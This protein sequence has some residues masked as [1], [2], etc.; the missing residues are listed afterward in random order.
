MAT[1]KPKR[2]RKAEYER[3]KARK[4]AEA[5]RVS[6]VEV[7]EHDPEEFR[8]RRDLINAELALLTQRT[9]DL[10]TDADRDIDF[11]YRHAGNPNLTPLQAPSIGAWQWYEYSRNEPSKFLEITQKREDAKAKIAGTITSQRMEDDKRQ[12]FAIID[13]IE[14][15]LTIDVK[16]M[17]KDLM[18]KFPM[19]VL[20][21][22][23]KYD[24]AWKKFLEMEANSVR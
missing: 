24:A 23:R 1:E 4:A 8:R 18:D 12:Q 13:R 20:T 10:P 9:C 16:A 6:S 19:D 22:C 7:S 3:R 14:K 17:V 15:Q 5:K 2:D 21:E 11:A